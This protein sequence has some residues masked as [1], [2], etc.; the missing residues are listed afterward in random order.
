MGEDFQGNSGRLQAVVIN[1]MSKINNVK[2]IFIKNFRTRT[3]SV[4]FFEITLV[5]IQAK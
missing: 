4:R 2:S 3:R 5:H 1:R